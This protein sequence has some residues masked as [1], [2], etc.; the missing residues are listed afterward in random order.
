MFVVA[1]VCDADLEDT[2]TA[3]VSLHFAKVHPA[4]NFASLHDVPKSRWDLSFESDK[5]AEK[6]DEEEEKKKEKVRKRERS[7]DLNK[8]QTQTKKVVSSERVNIINILNI[9][10]NDETSTDEEEDEEE[11]LEADCAKRPKVEL[12]PK[13][14]GSLVRASEMSPDHRRFAG[15]LIS[16]PYIEFPRQAMFYTCTVCQ[17]EPTFTSLAQFEKHRESDN[18]RVKY[19]EK[20][21]G[22]N[23]R[24]FPDGA[25]CN[26]RLDLDCCYC[27]AKVGAG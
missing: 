22:N 20:F 1:R 19:G 12:S 8:N 16:L 10:V 27:P 18:H 15:A 2:T 13:N 14:D 9:D 11:K 6:T 23:C 7:R 4:E 3:T 26:A 5:S 17:T 25:H 24:H 21:R